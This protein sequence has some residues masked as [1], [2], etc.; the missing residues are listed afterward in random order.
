MVEH[1][2]ELKPQAFV[3]RA[4]GLSF[5][6]IAR[7]LKNRG[8][9]VPARTLNHWAVSAEGAPLIEQL[10]AQLRAGMHEQAAEVVP[11]LFRKIRAAARDGDAKAADAWSRAIAN[12]TRGIV[13]DKVEVTPP[14]GP[15]DDREL[16]ALLARHGVMLNVPP[17]Q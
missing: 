5:R 9:P 3:L 6:R 17:E 7:V 1:S 14:S 15:T 8:T 2:N 4:Q 12:I 16:A 10:S 11:A 13:A